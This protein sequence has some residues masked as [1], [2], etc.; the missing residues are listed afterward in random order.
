MVQAVELAREAFALIDKDGDGTLS[1][2]E[3][4]R[5]FRLNPMVREQTI[6][7]PPSPPPFVS[8]TT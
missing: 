3:V 8:L 7:N 6:P 2:R 4:L 1:R 5:A